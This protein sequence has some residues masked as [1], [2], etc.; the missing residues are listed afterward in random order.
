MA[1]SRASFGPARSPVST[2]RELLRHSSRLAVQH[3]G[4]LSS[5]MCDT[6]TAGAAAR[7]EPLHGPNGVFHVRRALE[8]RP[9][10]V[11]PLLKLG[12]A[13]EVHRVIFKR[14]PPDEEPIPRRP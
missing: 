13:P 10:K 3:A 12:R 11:A 7:S 2:G 4:S 8:A 14:F 9:D 1:A 5:A 6:G